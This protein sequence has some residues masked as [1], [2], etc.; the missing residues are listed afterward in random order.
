VAEPIIQLPAEPHDRQPLLG[1]AMVWTAALL[2]AVNG[3]VSKIVLDSARLSTVELTQVR[4]T[5]ACS[6]SRSCW[7]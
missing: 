3:T 7:R 6:A 1:Y 5:G 2:F 4:S